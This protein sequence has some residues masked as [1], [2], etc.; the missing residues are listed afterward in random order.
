[1]IYI[2]MGFFTVKDITSVRFK[3]GLGGWVN[4]KAFQCQGI[5]E[6]FYVLLEAD[7]QKIYTYTTVLNDN[8]DSEEKI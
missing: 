2:P 8:P 6:S 4:M 7:N 5:L 1:M 3:R